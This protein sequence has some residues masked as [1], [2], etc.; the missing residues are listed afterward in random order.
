MGQAV[1]LQN[2]AVFITGASSGIGA[3][4]ARELAA[5]GASLAL[6]ARRRERLEELA[7]KLGARVKVTTAVADVTHDGALEEAVR[8]AEEALGGIDVVIANAG[9]GVVGRFERLTIDDYRRQLET[10]VFGVLRTIYATLPALKRSRGRLA[11]MGSVA[12]H[13]ATPRSSPYSMSK[14]ALRALAECLRE[15]LAPQGVTVTLISPGFVVSEIGHV[16]NQGLW[17]A[18]DASSV[19]AWLRMPTDRAAREI[20]A[21]IAAGRREAIITAH[22]K[23]AVFLYRHFPWLVRAAIHAGGRRDRSFRRSLQK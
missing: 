1:V 12:G 14:F 5:H 16:D 8:A 10:N 13:V 11:I 20:V 15:E 17:H 19:P 23:L 2:K 7:T 3:A 6:V 21:A 22:G 4:L 18:E 9:F